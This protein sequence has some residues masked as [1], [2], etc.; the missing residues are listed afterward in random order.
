M[1]GRSEILPFVERFKENPE[2]YSLLGVMADR[3]DELGEDAHAKF[4][5]EWKLNDDPPKSWDDEI[6]KNGDVVFVTHTARSWH[7]ELW[8]GLVRLVSG[9]KVDWGYVAGRAV[10]KVEKDL[11]NERA[12]NVAEA[13][14]DLMAI[15]W[16]YY[17]LEDPDPRRNPLVMPGFY[18][19]RKMKKNHGGEYFSSSP[20][21]VYS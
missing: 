17:S 19:D 20:A 8:V 14:D 15:L 9:E 2:E 3:L 7:V 18:V 5:R 10:V 1:A 12:K 4:F 21:A 6:Q 11:P 16:C 13:M